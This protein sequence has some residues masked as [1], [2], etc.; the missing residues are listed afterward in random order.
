M[1]NAR[2]P[3][4]LSIFALPGKPEAGRFFI[5]TG[6]LVAVSHGKTPER[7]ELAFRKPVVPR[8]IILEAFYEFRIVE[9][10]LAFGGRSIP[11]VYS[12]EG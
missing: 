3:Y 1:R 5:E 11:F 10:F 8:E 9:L 12:V 2:L 4:R 7:L 6:N